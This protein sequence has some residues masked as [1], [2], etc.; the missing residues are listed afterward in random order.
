MATELS[1]AVKQAA[2][3]VR[4]RIEGLTE[5][6][7]AEEEKIKKAMQV[8]HHAPHEMDVAIQA[9]DTKALVLVASKTN[10]AEKVIIAAQARID[11]ALK[12]LQKENAM[13]ARLLGH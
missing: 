2:Q 7:E 5:D 9:G 13:L 8:I 11:E 10:G 6:I 1:P 4:A 12:S 3:K